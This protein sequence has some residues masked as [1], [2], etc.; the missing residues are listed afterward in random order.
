[1]ND[2]SAPG[3]PAATSEGGAGTPGTERRASGQ[4]GCTENES[5]FSCS[6][7]EFD[8]FDAQSEQLDGHRQDYLKLS[9][10]P[11]RGRLVS[12]FLGMGVS[13]HRE[14]VNCAM[15][16]RV[17]CPEGLIELGVS[18][19][20][21]PVAVNGIELGCDDVVVAR[22]GSELE[23]DIPQEGAE[24]L[25]L[26]VE[27]SVLKSLIRMDTGLELLDPHGHGASVA[28]AACLASA[29]EIG[30]RTMLRTCAQ[31]PAAW[32]PQ[33]A[34]PALAAE[35][36]AALE[37][38]ACLG[39]ARARTRVKRS[40]AVLAAARDALSVMEEFDYATLTAATG[41]SPRSIQLAFAE[42][43]QMTP[44]RYFRTIRLHRARHTLLTGVGGRSATIGDIAAAH[45]FWNWSLFTQLYRLQF[46]E[47]PSETRARANVGDALH[48]RGA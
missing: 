28:R 18:L 25:V 20:R 27:L 9:T 22:P 46:G 34:A 48:K 10:G 17:G 6:N 24:Y 41:G 21:P 8:D 14:T 11:F 33:D 12:A 3:K 26:A 16:Q 39:I 31:A 32:R 30:G 29:I 38:D 13:V 5:A 44:R 36:V 35:C 19:G 15:Y 40:A 4:D 47:A 43:I 23:L 7:M 45:G 2:D 42:R 37:L 1:M